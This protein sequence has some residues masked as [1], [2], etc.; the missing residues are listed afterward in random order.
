M[1]LLYKLKQILLPKKSAEGSKGTSESNNTNNDVTIVKGKQFG[2]AQSDKQKR[3]ALLTPREHELFLL[4]LEGYTLKESAGQL[5]V[6]YSTANT[7]MTGIYRKL[8]VNSRAEL[9]IHYRDIGKATG[10]D[11]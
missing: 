11:P 9:I 8:G 2:I 4:L 10:K 6:K 3:V 5:F 1:A 7:H